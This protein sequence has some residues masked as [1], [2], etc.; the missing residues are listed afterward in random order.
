[1]RKK[2]IESFWIGFFASLS[3]VGFI[4]D[5]YGQDKYIEYLKSHW[6]D[7]HWAWWIPC[8]IY[9]FYKFHLNVKIADLIDRLRVNH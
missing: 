9:C 6:F 2:I 1:M 5:W 7:L 4:Q 3:M 8:I